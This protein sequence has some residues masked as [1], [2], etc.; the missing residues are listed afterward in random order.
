MLALSRAMAEGAGNLT[1]TSSRS[2]ANS[3][4]L[5]FRRKN[6]GSTTGTVT[7]LAVLTRLYLL[8]LHTKLQHRRR[9][10]SRRVFEEKRSWNP[11]N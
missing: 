1:F 5:A 3:H 6:A 4:N 11:Q 2:Q 9:S 10:N 8:R 7:D